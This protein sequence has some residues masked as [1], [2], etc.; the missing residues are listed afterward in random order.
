MRTGDE[1]STKYLSTKSLVD[2]IFCRQ[3]QLSTKCFSTKQCRQK[4][5]DEMI[6]TKCLV[7]EISVDEMSVDDNLSTKKCRR[8]ERRQSIL[9]TNNMQFLLTTLGEHL[10]SKIWKSWGV[11]ARSFQDLRNTICLNKSWLGQIHLYR[12]SWK[13]LFKISRSWKDYQRQWSCRK[14][15]SET[16]SDT[17][18][19]QI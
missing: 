1:L 16:D 13:D 11:Q 19:E 3:S 6:S 5:V 15:F 7:D 18:S 17:T 14:I 9:S 12:R 10:V 4:V 2:K 8:N